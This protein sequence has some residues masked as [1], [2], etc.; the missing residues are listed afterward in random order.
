MNNKELAYFIL[1]ENE[2]FTVSEIINNLISKNLIK[3][4]A[5]DICRSLKIIEILIE[6][7]Y[8]SFINLEDELLLSTHLI[9]KG[10][11]TR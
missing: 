3:N 1:N 2:P 10:T 8:I 6:K 7:S 5:A 4:E 9:Q 11:I